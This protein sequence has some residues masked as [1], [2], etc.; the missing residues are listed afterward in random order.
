MVE[1][2]MYLAIG[3]LLSMLCGLAIVPLVHNRAVRLTTRRLEAAT[4][5]S[6]AEIQADKD[7]LRAEFAMSARRLEMSVDQLRNKTTSQLAELG[8]KTDAIN[9][10][11]L[12]L[13]EKNATIFSLEAREKAMKEQLRATEEEFA[14]KTGSLRSA[15]QALAD[16]QSELAKLNTELSDRSMMAESRQVELVSVRTQIDALKGRVT[17]AEK[18]Y[19]TTQARLE[20]ERRDSEKASR[21]L[22]EARSRVENLSQ[23]VTVL[24]RQLIIQ[25]KEAEMLGNRVSDLETR[26]TMQGKLLAERDY[27]NNQLRQARQTAARHQRDAAAGRNFVGDRADG[28]FAAART[29]QRHRRR[30]RQARDAD[31][32]AELVDRDDPGRTADDRQRHRARPWRRSRRR[33]A[34]RTHPRAAIPRLP[35]PPRG[36]TAASRSVFAKLIHLFECQTAAYAPCHCE[37]KRS[38]PSLH[39]K[40]EWIASSLALLA[41]TWQH[42]FVSRAWIAAC[43]AASQNRDPFVLEPRWVPV[44]QRIISLRSCCPAPGTRGHTSAFS[45]HILR[46]VFHFFGPSK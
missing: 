14:T 29:H 26:L 41:K 42:L 1:P 20:Q 4:P 17:E 28:K 5:L 38:N 36:V 7:Q 15:E 3:F 37:R 27:E 34:R 43:N 9:R 6:M 10:M 12:E 18:E 39:T 21:E 40:K 11:K 23:R 2:I 35:R 22:V 25:V 19:A 13:G 33:D 45:P 30:S 16:K 31:R 24:D 8:K 32:R 44:L 46:E